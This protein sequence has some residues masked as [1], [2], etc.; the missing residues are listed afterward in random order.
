MLGEA[1]L[2]IYSAGSTLMHTNTAFSQIAGCF[3]SVSPWGLKFPH[4]RD[5]K[6]SFALR[7]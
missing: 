6:N 5:Y 1:I 7:Q 3:R 2:T 4:K